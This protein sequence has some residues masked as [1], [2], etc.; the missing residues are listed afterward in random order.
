M[1]HRTVLLFMIV[2]AVAFA[3]GIAADRYWPSALRLSGMAGVGSEPHG[4]AHADTA[5]VC[6]MHPQIV[7]DKPGTCP[8]CGMALVPA[9]PAG[10]EAE[11]GMDAQPVVHIT[12]EVINNFGVKMTRV[13]R[14][15]L[16]RR[17]ETPGFVQQIEP[18]GHTRVK[19]PFEARIAALH[20]KPEQWL[21]QGKP[22]VTLAS[23]ALLEAEQSH[24][25]LIKHG[26]PMEAKPQEAAPTTPVPMQH[27]MTLEQSRERL[28]LLG[29]SSEDIQQLE[30]KRV[31]SST[32]TLYAP[33]PGMIS[34]LQAAVG[35]SVKSGTMLFEISGL[36]RAT[37][38]A[39][40]FQR[41]AA[42]IQTGQ[43]VEV[44]LPHVSS[45][46]WSGIV[47]QGA[48]SIDTNSQNIG[49]R[50][51]FTA[52]AHLLK[53]AM[54]VVATIQGDARHGVLAV[55]Q[56]A[57]IHTESGD[58]VVVA[59]G[60]GRFRPVSVRTG[61]ET[62]GKV[63]ILSGLKEGDDIVVSAQFLIDSESSLQ[64]SFRR[65]TPH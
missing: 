18:A 12:P 62:G 47:N 51:S 39:N 65:M 56:E 23:T 15:T 59:L 27:G 32:L 8:I 37:V 29:L 45:Q 21:E 1:Q 11:E 35:D 46:T 50:L 40:A 60:G 57:L 6:P 53:S 19:A 49:V 55:P 16:V 26:A 34:R 61:I 28:A 5:Y 25:D 7:S 2:L 22:L 9:K 3:A 52:P 43:A 63:E 54:Y 48:V 17:I 64:A 14:T 41:D 4:H 44:K 58:R 13:T 20:F 33:Y 36:A 38:L 30:L 31:P 10:V 42:W 24:V